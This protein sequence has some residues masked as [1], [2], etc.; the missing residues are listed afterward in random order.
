MKL[1]PSLRSLR[2]DDVV[3]PNDD[4]WSLLTAYLAHQTSHGQTISLEVVG[5][6]P[7]ECPEIVN[8]IGCLVKEF[9][10]RQHRILEEYEERYAGH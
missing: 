1:F 10:H 2:P 6:F 9:T 7:H 8:G 3:S 4:D 5:G